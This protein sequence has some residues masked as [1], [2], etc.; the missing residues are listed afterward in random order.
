MKKVLLVIAVTM[1]VFGLAGV[2][3]AKM[4]GKGGGK[5]MGMGKGMDMGEHRMMDHLAGLGLN[6]QQK[7]DIKAVHSRMKK[8][9]I[10]KGAEI[11]V[12]RMELQDMLDRDQ[13]DM[14]AV[15][16]KIRQ[17]EGLK[18]DLA[19]A[20]IRS[21]EEVKAKLTPEQRKKFAALHEEGGM[22]CMMGRGGMGGGCGCRM[23]QH[24]DDDDHDDHD[25]HGRGGHE[26]HE[27][28]G[29]GHQH[30]GGKD[31]GQKHH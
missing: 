18:T 25:G 16:A 19:M 27:G 9:M 24:G 17:V 3:D 15:E 28:H 30:H 14:K 7:A 4:C 23:M 1:L 2:S 31:S 10:R 20:R 6:D 26:G 11:K 8:E 13:V 29:E 21:H 22:S 5:G 12:S